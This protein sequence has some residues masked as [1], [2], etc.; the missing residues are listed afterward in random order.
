[1]PTALIAHLAT[2]TRWRAYVRQLAQDSIDIQGL[3]LIHERRARIARYP[4]MRDA[5]LRI[6]GAL[7]TAVEAVDME[8]LAAAAIVADV[9]RDFDEMQT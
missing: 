8:M 2:V 6:A 1:M 5:Q 4:G 3:V 7:M 9:E